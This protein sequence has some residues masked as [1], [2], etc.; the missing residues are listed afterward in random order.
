M[1][2]KVKKGFGLKAL[3]YLMIAL[4]LLSFTVTVFCFI[5][6]FSLPILFSYE[7][8]LNFIKIF[9]NFSSVY[10]ATFVVFAI[11]VA[12]DQ[13]REMKHSNYE[14][15]KISNKSLWY[16]DLKNKL[17]EVRKTNNHL[18]NHIVFNINKVYDFLYEKDFQIKSKVEL[19][20]FIEKFFIQE[21]PNFE[22]FDYNTASY[23]YA[24]KNENQLHSFGTFYD[25]FIS[26][27]RP[28]DNYTNFHDD[29]RLIFLEA[30]KNSKI[31][32]I[33][34]ESFYNHQVQEALKARLFDT[35]EN[36]QLTRNSKRP[37]M[38][39]FSFEY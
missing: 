36:I 1:T 6:A 33:I 31:E 32:R 5:K 19:E 17:D 4:L 21:I 11:Y 38:Q 35:K 20:E 9:E 27:V 12:F 18:Y 7:G 22:R 10:A 26:I 2:M 39:C 8:L 30:V 25:L 28:S 14:A 37:P 16:N 3:K 29:L 34:G 15:I 23:G 13:L 24:Y